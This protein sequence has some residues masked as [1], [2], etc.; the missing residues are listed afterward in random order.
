MLIL[1]DPYYD[2]LGFEISRD[3]RVE[4]VPLEHKV[5]PDGESYFRFL[6][7]V[8][9]E[10][11]LCVLSSYPNQDKAI[12]RAIFFLRT[13]RDLGAKKIIAVIPYF[14]YA[15]QDKR[16]LPGECVS[17]RVVAETIF[18]AG[19]DYIITVDVHSEKVFENFGKRFL[20]IKAV[21]AWANY[22][23]ANYRTDDVF[24]IAPDKGRIDYVEAVA[25][26]LDVPF[27]GF[28]KRR[29]LVSGEIKKH[30]PINPEKFG[31]LVKSRKV[32]ILL[33]DIIS[34]GGTAAGVIKELRKIFDGKIVAGFTHGLFLPGSIEKLLKAGADEIVSTNTVR[35]SF[36]KVSV[37]SIIVEEI[38]KI[39]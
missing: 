30:Q 25:S 39:L 10:D 5:F 36:A 17:A 8:A 7:D 35:N 15:R 20:N 28:E 26:L 27:T 18:S 16:F 24:I 34:T 21:K 14:P 11:V 13:L 31:T 12:L 38:R 22:I 19:A 32:A 1:V 9:G 2:A 33:D 6:R 4:L 37:A 3:L 29:D 23:K